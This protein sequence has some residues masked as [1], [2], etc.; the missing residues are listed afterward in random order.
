VR[1]ICNVFGRCDCQLDIFA[2][3]LLLLF[4]NNNKSVLLIEAAAG[5]ADD[6]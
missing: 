4:T 5:A 1:L 3:S 6:A 2:F